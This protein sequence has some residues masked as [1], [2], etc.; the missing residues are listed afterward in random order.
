MVGAARVTQQG[1][2]SRSS[3]SFVGGLTGVLVPCGKGKSV[4]KG[5]G[6]ADAAANAGVGDAASNAGVGGPP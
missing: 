2:P 5:K 6:A 4:R 3:S 1:A